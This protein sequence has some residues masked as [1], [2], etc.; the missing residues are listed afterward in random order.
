M[1]PSGRAKYLIAMLMIG[2]GVMAAVRPERDADAWSFGPGAWRALMRAL[3]ERP[4]LLRTLG[5]AEAGVALWWALRRGRTPET[6]G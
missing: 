4:N 3:A 1:I 6:R 2:D 5:I